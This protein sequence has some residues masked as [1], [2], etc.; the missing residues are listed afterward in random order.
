MYKVALPIAVVAQE[1][2]VE[3]LALLGDVRVQEDR[4]IANRRELV[5]AEILQRLVV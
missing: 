1:V 3:A 2:V 5:E 4:V